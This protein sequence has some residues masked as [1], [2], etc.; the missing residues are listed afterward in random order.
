MAKCGNNIIYLLFE[1]FK[2]VS[3]TRFLLP[4]TAWVGKLRPAR[5]PYAS[6]D[7][8]R[9]NVAVSLSIKLEFLRFYS[10]RFITIRINTQPEVTIATYILC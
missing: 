1:E 4:T 8:F 5:P 6:K 3:Q 2:D 10:T 7:I 9:V